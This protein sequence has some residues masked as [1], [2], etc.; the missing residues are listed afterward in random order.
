MEPRSGTQYVILE[1]KFSKAGEREQGE[2]SGRGLHTAPAV[3]RKTS[4]RPE[5]S[6]EPWGASVF[7]ESGRQQV[8]MHHGNP[9]QH[10]GQPCA[11]LVVM[12]SQKCAPPEGYVGDHRSAL[13]RP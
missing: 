9:G 11:F 2:L 6:N 4:M 13:G 12:D 1:A 7:H 3:I 8:R 5:Q 10:V